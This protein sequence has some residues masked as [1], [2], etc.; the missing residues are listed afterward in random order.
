LSSEEISVNNR[1]QNMCF[2]LSGTYA[3]ALL[4]CFQ[5]ML[6]KAADEPAPAITVRYADLN[7]SQPAGATVLYH[8]I[9]TA[10]REVCPS[11]LIGAI[12]A[13]QEQRACFKKAVDDAVN[14]VHSPA[15]SALNQ[16]TPVRLAKN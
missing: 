13:T 1:Y 11:Y 4:C 6:A 5:P 8:R 15:L 3:A 16:S 9:Q 12:G 10:A 7:I 2:A 14:S